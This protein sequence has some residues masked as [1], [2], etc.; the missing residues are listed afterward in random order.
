MASRTAYDPKNTRRLWENLTYFDQQA[1]DP[2]TGKNGWRYTP[3]VIEPAAGATRTVLCMLIDAYNEEVGVDAKGNEKVRTV[4]KLHPRLA[5][6]KAAVLPLTKKDV[7]P[8]V[9]RKIVDQFFKAGINA[10]YDDN[11]S[12]GKRYARHDEV[13]TP[14]CLTVDHQTLEDQTI[15]I[16]NRDTTEQKRISV[17]DALSEVKARLEM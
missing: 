15:T 13:G 12:I 9:A 4:L 14:Y 8:D 16:R 17:E 10:K 7:L 1:T 6:I 11:T 3:Y 2:E 5:P